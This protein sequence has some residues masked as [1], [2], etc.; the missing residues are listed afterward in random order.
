[1]KNFLF[2]FAFLLFSCGSSTSDNSTSTTTSQNIDNSTSELNK[3]KPPAETETLTKNTQEVLQ[4]TPQNNQTVTESSSGTKPEVAPP[5]T[6]T[7][8]KKSQEKEVKTVKPKTQSTVKTEVASKVETAKSKVVSTPPPP[9]P[10][11]KVETPVIEKPVV[12]KPKVEKPVVAPKKVEAPKV[13]KPKKM[14]TVN[15]QDFDGLLRKYVS[16]SGKVNYA[17]IKNDVSKLDAYLAKLEKVKVSDLSGRNE[18]MAFYINAYN[19]YTL[20]L[21]VKNYPLSSIT[22]LHGGKPW[23]VKWINLDGQKLSLNNIENDI[24]RPVYKD[25]RIH[26][27]VNCA[28][29]SCPPLLNKAWTANNLESNFQKQTKKFVNDTNFNKINDSSIE[30]SKIFEWYGK[31]FGNLVNFLNKYSSTK[32]NT[33]AKVNY[34]DYNWAL[35]N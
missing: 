8:S 11:P 21:I 31:D 33:D 22:D 6:Q 18:K 7:A 28:A 14:N 19:A 13:E 35:N 32:I 16:A 10:T 29:K 34:V 24:L 2:I 23:D 25:A 3:M 4:E 27:A 26:F 17:G 1:M 20:K 30:I 9:A 5:A 12:E 15:H